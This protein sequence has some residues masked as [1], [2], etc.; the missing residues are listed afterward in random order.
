MIPFPEPL[1]VNEFAENRF[2]TDEEDEFLFFVEDTLYLECR[3]LSRETFN[4]L[5]ILQTCA[6]YKAEEDP[7]YKET[8]SWLTSLVCDHKELECLS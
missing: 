1:G 2:F 5:R 3:P 8:F 7:R 6:G 4:R